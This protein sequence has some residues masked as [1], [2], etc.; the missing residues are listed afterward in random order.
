MRVRLDIAAFVR[1]L[2][3]I[4]LLVGLTLSLGCATRPS[5]SSDPLARQDARS[6]TTREI[7]RFVIPEPANARSVESGEPGESAGVEASGERVSTRSARLDARWRVV[8]RAVAHHGTANRDAF[9]QSR[10]HW[11]ADSAR[12]LGWALE[13]AGDL[14]E[15]FYIAGRG[16]VI[17]RGD[18]NADLE[19]AG[20][21]VVH[22]LGDLD[23]TLELKG[24]CEVVIAGDFTERATLVCDGQLELFI[25]GDAAGIL[26]ATRSATIVIDGHATGTL[27]CGAP[28]T[29]LTVTGDLVGR[30]VPP[31]NKDAALTLRVDGFTPS[32]RM[33]T[34]A[35]AGFARL[36]ATLA[37]SDAPP[38]L[39]P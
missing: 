21:A 17:V 12:G 16:N 15:P 33:Q 5:V 3:V 2:R 13:Q 11:H 26:G 6:I 37:A 36:T 10:A 23:A 9:F 25:A 39:Y 35:T 34:L 29:A 8:Q 22:I 19:V 32:A 1:A 30:V 4:V 14:D 38:G 24:I 18:V 27:Q 20:N 28:A 7:D 31:N